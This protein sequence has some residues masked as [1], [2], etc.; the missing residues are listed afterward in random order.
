MT[1]VLRDRLGTTRALPVDDWCAPASVDERALLSALRG[2]VL[3]LGCGP[4]RLVVALGQLG[5]P[6]L[7]ID[8]SPHAVGRAVASGAPVLERSVFERLPGEGRWASVLVFDGNVGIGGAPAALLGRARELIAHDGTVIVE[9]EPP[10]SQTAMTEARLERDG[11]R[12]SW[13]PWAWVAADALDDIAA[14]AG[15]RRRRWRRIGGRWF[16]DLGAVPS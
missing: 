14:R 3:D 2:P 4:G 6:A 12:T 5:I 7:G 10:G 15:L 16:A 1:V 8:A 9:V 13:F 11:E